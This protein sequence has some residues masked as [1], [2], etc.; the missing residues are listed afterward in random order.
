[1]SWIFYSGKA[2][3]FSGADGDMILQ[4]INM[5]IGTQY[6]LVFTISGMTQGVLEV[7]GFEESFEFTEDGT[8]AIVGTASNDK[9]TFLG[10]EDE[11]EFLFDGCID[12]VQAYTFASQTSSACS[13]CINVREDQDDCL[14]LITAENDNNAL[15]FN[16][17]GLTLK[18]RIDA[19]FARVDYSTNKEDLDDNGGDHIVT[20]FDG[21]KNRDLLVQAA[22]IYIHD[23][24]F[25][26]MGVDTFKINGVEYSIVD[27]KY[28]AI[29]WNKQFTEGAVEIKIRKKNYK[30]TKTNCG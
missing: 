7:Q 12:S 26:C 6:V 5:S 20:Y 25:M 29:E 11:S 2:C 18:A 16:W 22:P 27:D 17:T 14:L 19:R 10:R 28:P 9:V 8:Y 3:L 15:N 21:K 4:D 13:P 1:M 23:F 30:L 24:L